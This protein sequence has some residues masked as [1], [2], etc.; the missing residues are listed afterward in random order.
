MRALCFLQQ[1]FSFSVGA[2]L[3]AGLTTPVAGLA[4]YNNRSQMAII[5]EHE[6][7]HTVGPSDAYKNWPSPQPDCTQTNTIMQGVTDLDT[8]NPIAA[9]MGGITSG[10]VAQSNRQ[11]VNQPSCETAPAG[12]GDS[13]ENPPCPTR[14]SCGAYINP[15]YCTYG[16][17]N[18]GC[19]N[20]AS[21]IAGSQGQ[22][23]C[24]TRS[25]I[26]VDLNGDGFDLTSSE[27]DEL[28]TLSEFGVKAISL[29]Y[30]VS[31]WVD[32]YGNQ[33][34]YKAEIRDVDVRRTARWTYDVFLLEEPRQ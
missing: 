24:S 25:P 17:I 30:K 28:H 10:D 31:Q 23:C 14:P 1:L 21:I 32:I 26:I 19:P 6:F 8:C 9:A 7:G 22:D 27:P 29:R 16:R 33:F 4:T 3:L 18:S 5:L 13:P 2:V 12:Q 34:R 11:A 20:G 15:D